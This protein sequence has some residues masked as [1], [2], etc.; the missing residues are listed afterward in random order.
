MVLCLVQIKKG[1]RNI[2]FRAAFAMEIDQD[3]SD[4]NIFFLFQH[5]EETGDGAKEASTTSKTARIVLRFT[6]LTMTSGMI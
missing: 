6:H 4:N 5:A 2:A 3:G 1:N